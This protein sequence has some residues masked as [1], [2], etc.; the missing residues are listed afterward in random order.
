VVTALGVNTRGCA[1]R[2]NPACC[3]SFIFNWLHFTC[4]LRVVEPIAS[5]I[6]EADFPWPANP[7]IVLMALGVN[8]R[9]RAPRGNPACCLSFIFNWLHFTCT[10]RVVEPITSAISE[11]GFPWPANPRIVVTALGVNTRGR[12]PRGQSRR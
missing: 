9:G 3:L 1:P 8:T 7:R 4:T 5:A 6:S 10:L 11:A 12:A 2:G